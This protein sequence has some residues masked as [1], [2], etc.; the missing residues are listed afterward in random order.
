[1]REAVVATFG[2]DPARDW[3]GSSGGGR[4]QGDWRP[5][6]AT[7]GVDRAVRILDAPR[8]DAISWIAIV[9][10]V[11]SALAAQRLAVGDIDEIA[12][13]TLLRLLQAVARG[14]EIRDL[15]GYVRRVAASA[16]CEWLGRDRRHARAV[17]MHCPHALARLGFAAAAAPAGDGDGGASEAAVDAPSLRAVAATLGPRA[18]RVVA[19]WKS[20]GTVKGAARQLGLDA[21]QVK[22]ILSK[23]AGDIVLA[24]HRAKQRDESCPPRRS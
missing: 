13:E 1:M 4:A 8:D 15:Q 7:G 22:R 2:A 9:A 17:Q 20:C 14:A 16:R 18:L 12:Q 19:A 23:V 5:A 24:R 10:W 3:L 21:R 6:A 11:R